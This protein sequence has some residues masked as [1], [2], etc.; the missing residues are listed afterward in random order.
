MRKEMPWKRMN[1]GIV[2]TLKTHWP[3]QGVGQLCCLSSSDWYS[4]H[5]HSTD[6][7]SYY[8]F[9]KSDINPWFWILFL[10]D[11]AVAIKDPP[12]PASIRNENQQW[13]PFQL[14]RSLGSSRLFKE[15]KALVTE[16]GFSPACHKMSPD[17]KPSH[18]YQCSPTALPTNVTSFFPPT[19]KN[20]TKKRRRRRKK[21]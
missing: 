21:S 8:I 13:P 6:K 10:N 19:A 4:R 3:P 7:C 9:W 17:T 16:L 11:K 12:P 20:K 18:S 2:F 14:T 15:R 5:I 1:H